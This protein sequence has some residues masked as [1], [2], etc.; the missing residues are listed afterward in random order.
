MS[1]SE[2]TVLKIAKVLQR[3]FDRRTG[4]E[5]PWER[6]SSNLQREFLEDAR[7]VLN[8]LN[9]EVTA[10]PTREAQIRYH[11]DALVRMGASEQHRHL[12]AVAGMAHLVI[13]PKKR[14]H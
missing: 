7:E 10:E 9:E 8:A 1:K 2:E 14:C 6:E 3:Q 4:D 12:G 11:V 5:I 13:L